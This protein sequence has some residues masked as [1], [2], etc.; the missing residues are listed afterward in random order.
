MI[1]YNP[2]VSGSLLVTGSLTT[3]GTL[4]AQTLVVQTITS[5]VDFVTGSSVNGSLSSNT[6]QFTGSV[7]ITGSNAALLSVNNNV[8]Y[9]SSSGNVLIGTTTGD[10]YKLQIVGANQATSTF[11]QTYAGVAAYSQWISSSGAFVMGLDG[12][13][14]TTPRI[15]I[16]STG[17]VGIGTSSPADKLEIYNGT[18][19]KIKTFF[20]GSYTSGFKFSDYN[21][22][23]RYDA[24]TDRLTLFA[25]YPGDAEI[26]FETS[27]SERMRITSAGRVGVGVT[28]PLATLHSIGTRLHLNE[29]GKAEFIVAQSAFT[30]PTVSLITFN[31]NA[32]Y[33]QI[34]V[35]VTVFQNSVSGGYGNVQVGYA[36]YGYNA[37]PTV[38]TTYTSTMAS[39]GGSMSNVGTLAW[40]GTTLTYTTNRVTNYDRYQIILEYGSTN[41]NLDPSFPNL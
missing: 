9:V 38:S 39:A 36:V 24:G 35:R 16:S 22:G 23:I 12:A 20:D 18:Y 31:A 8:L 6:H 14:G 17:N 7:L 28:A 40:S 29:Y 27:G 26:T 5:S 30:N 25:N 10:N 1:L 21:G 4:T 2:T 37:Y 3:T 13:A 32:N 15:T 41:M 19:H 34:T 33:A 11:G